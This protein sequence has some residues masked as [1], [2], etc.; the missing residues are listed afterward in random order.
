MIHNNC[1]D[2]GDALCDALGVGPL[3]RR[4]GMSVHSKASADLRDWVCMV[5][6]RLLVLIL[7]TVLMCKFQII[8]VDLRVDIH[9]SS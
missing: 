5:F 7:R 9:W 2:F 3:P 6:S 8:G 1:L 4:A